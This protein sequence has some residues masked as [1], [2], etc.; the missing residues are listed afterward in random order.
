M[1]STTTSTND[2]SQSRSF[3][4]YYRADFVVTENTCTVPIEL[5][6]VGDARPTV[7]FL[8]GPTEHGFWAGSQVMPGLGSLS[9]FGGNVAGGI[10][11]DTGGC[12]NEPGIG[13]EFCW[14]EQLFIPNA[15]N[16]ATLVATRYNVGNGADCSV[17][18]DADSLLTI[19]FPE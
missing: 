6:A 5:G 9:L 4:D 7:F 11:A 10:L 1:S 13:A 15:G 18:Y 19:D 2:P 14:I 3:N 17:R 12:S 8:Y 16:A